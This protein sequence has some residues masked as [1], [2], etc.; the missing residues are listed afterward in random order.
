MNYQKNVDSEDFKTKCGV[1]LHLPTFSP[2]KIQKSSLEKQFGKLEFDEESVDNLVESG[3]DSS[4]SESSEDNEHA[5]HSS[6]DDE[7]V[8]QG[9]DFI[10]GDL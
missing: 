5:A 8:E 3:D 10:S 4:Q 1:S 7:N 9:S 6:S 2:G